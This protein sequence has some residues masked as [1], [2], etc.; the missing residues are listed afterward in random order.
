LQEQPYEFGDAF[1]WEKFC[2]LCWGRNTSGCRPFGALICCC[3]LPRAR[4]LGYFMSPRW[5]SG[6]CVAVAGALSRRSVFQG[7]AT[8]AERA[9]LKRRWLRGG[10]V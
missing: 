9:K 1:Y 8:L 4:A 6:D 5:G 3:I 2:N 7:L 10:K